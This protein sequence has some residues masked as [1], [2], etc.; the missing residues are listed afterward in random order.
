MIK[1]ILFDFDG[2]L[3]DTVQGIVETLRESFVRLGRPVPRRWEI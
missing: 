2:T 1:N 3:A